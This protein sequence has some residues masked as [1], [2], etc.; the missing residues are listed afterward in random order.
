MIIF[1]SILFRLTDAKV[2]AE[3]KYPTYLSNFEDRNVL[4]LDLKFS[5][6]KAQDHSYYNP[7]E[8]K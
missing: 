3:R 4:F 8:I 2:I 5:Q 7:Y 1:Y 6:E